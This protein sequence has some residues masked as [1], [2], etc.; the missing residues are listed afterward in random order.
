MHKID[1]VVWRNDEDA[2]FE[3]L[4]RGDED[5]SVA[6]GF[7]VSALFNITP[8]TSGFVMQHIRRHSQAELT[9]SPPGSRRRS[10]FAL[11]YDPSYYNTRMEGDYYELFK[12]DKRGRHVDPDG[13]MLSMT[14][15]T[16]QQAPLDIERIVEYNQELIQAQ[17]GIDVRHLIQEMR[18]SV[19]KR[20]RRGGDF[21]EYETHYTT[22]AQL[23]HLATRGIYISEHT[24]VHGMVTFHK[25][26]ESAVEHYL[27][28]EDV[29]FTETT[30]PQPEGSNEF[31]AYW[32]DQKSMAGGLLYS[33]INPER[34]LE[35]FPRSSNW[36]VHEVQAA[37]SSRPESIDD[38]AYEER[39]YTDL[40]EE[41]GLERN[42]A[43][44][45]PIPMKQYVMLGD[46]GGLIMSRGGRVN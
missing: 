35:T 9:F 16:F 22:Q 38:E 29:E 20:R 17:I 7:S 2:S 36:Y 41:Y 33:P 24:L 43:S 31:Y 46:D 13:S 12:I 45:E 30:P 6:G 8:P 42:D 18:R 25:G 40:H 28:A 27:S 44:I 3:S 19:R 23:D 26:S 10:S 34:F 32:E 21:V 39:Y 5:T 4:S 37:W 15:D 14:P 11:D 1:M